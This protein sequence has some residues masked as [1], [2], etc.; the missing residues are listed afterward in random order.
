MKTIQLTQGKTAIID[1]EDYERVSRF[2]WYAFRN[3]HGNWYARR[4]PLGTTQCMHRF[5][6]D[7]P[8]HYPEVDHVD[9]DGLNN[10]RLNLRTA[11]TAQNQANSRTR[12][13]NSSGYKGVGRQQRSSKWHARIKVSGKTLQLGVYDTPEA[14]AKAY[15]SKALELRGPFARVNFTEVKNG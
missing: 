9:G 12:K 15:D 2:R 10:R 8:P 3:Q 11:T 6:L 5:I 7:L 4:S 14:A 1:D 13:D